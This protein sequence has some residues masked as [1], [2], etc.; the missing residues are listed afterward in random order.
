MSH[1]KHNKQN[2]D[3]CEKNCDACEKKCNDVCVVDIHPECPI[4][5]M[6]HMDIVDDA[7]IEFLHSVGHLQQL[8]FKNINYL[9][10]KSVMFIVPKF[11]IDNC[12]NAYSLVL[13][14]DVQLMDVNYANVDVQ[15]FSIENF[16]GI[17]IPVNQNMFDEQND[18]ILYVNK[19]RIDLTKINKCDVRDISNA[20]KWLPSSPV[21]EN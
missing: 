3:D 10:G 14:S 2:H 12:D 16:Y 7:M 8:V 17:K 20:W 21:I 11:L 15:I 19:I 1:K 9:I 6:R 4:K 18:Y 5:L 13:D